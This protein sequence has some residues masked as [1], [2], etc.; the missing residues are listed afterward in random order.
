MLPCGQRSTPERRTICDYTGRLGDE[1]HN[2]VLAVALAQWIARDDSKADVGRAP[3]REHRH[4]RDR[5]HAARAVPA[6]GSARYRDP[7][8]PSDATAARV[9]E[10]L[11]QCREERGQLN[12][13]PARHARTE[14]RETRASCW[15][16]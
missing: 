3:G 15:R 1:G 7:R 11:R 16:A 6:P 14:C 9:D 5:R 10:L 4:G 12:D 13:P 8:G 2:G